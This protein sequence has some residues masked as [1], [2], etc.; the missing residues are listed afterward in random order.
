ML[1]IIS[2]YTK[3]TNIFYSVYHGRTTLTYF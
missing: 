1:K 3:R 2:Q